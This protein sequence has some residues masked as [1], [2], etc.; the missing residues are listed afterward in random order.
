MS[1]MKSEEVLTGFAALAELLKPLGHAHR[2]GLLSMIVEQPRSVEQLAELSGLTIAN[3]SQHLQHL[4]RARLVCSHREG[5]NVVYA[6][7]EGP[8]AQLIRAACALGAYHD[9]SL[10]ILSDAAFEHRPEVKAIS[11]SDLES[12]LREK[13]IILLDVRENTLYRLGHLPNA[14]NVPL[15][16]LSQRLAELPDDV[17]VVTY[18]HGPYCRLSEQAAK[19]LHNDGYV[20]SRLQSGYL[21]WEEAGLPINRCDER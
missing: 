5:K 10:Q 4:K 8:I 17:E 9:D 20:V 2:L 18:C 14:M 6:V 15:E 16:E 12:K 1:T 3:A 7:G 13:K 11:R 19:L 21:R